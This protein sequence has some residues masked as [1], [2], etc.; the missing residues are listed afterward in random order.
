[1]TL[2]VR[3]LRARA[4]GVAVVTAS[5]AL[6]APAAPVLAAPV[7]PTS[8]SIRV[9]DSPVGPTESARIT[10]HLVVAG[11]PA[12]AGR[13]VTLEAKPLGGTEFVPV[14]ETHTR[15]RGGVTA[16]V[17]P[18]VTTRY[19]WHYAGDDG[20]RQSYS[21]VG[22]VRVTDNAHVPHRLATSLSIREVHRLTNGGLV[23]IVRGQ[24]RAGRLALPHRP[25]ILLSRTSDAAGWS[26]EHI[27]MTRRHGVVRF[28]VDPAQDTAYRMVFLGTTRLQPARSG[29]VRVAAR[30]DVTIAADPS[31][32]ALGDTT[33]I[34]SAV[35]FAGAPVAGAQVSL[36]AVKAGRPAAA[37]RVVET[38]TTGPDG[39]VSFT[40]TPAVSTKYRLR[41][42]PTNGHPGTISA[43]V[44]VTVIRLPVG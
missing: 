40:E 1:M 14:V 20:T 29:M 16:E 12:A 21:G 35:T 7:A 33:T 42:A 32:V 18:Q 25:V 23:D 31:A 27:A 13:V 34:T 41:V 9:V 43:V 44:L 38:G 39:S 5:V 30:P 4:V 36:I 11:S 22:V 26:F 24:L 3:S 15:E 19:R 8:L 17:I 37:R 28:V 2:S 6:L 10:G